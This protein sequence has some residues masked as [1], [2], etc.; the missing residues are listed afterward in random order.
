M[1]ELAYGAVPGNCESVLPTDEYTWLRSMGKALISQD[2]YETLRAA[3]QHVNLR[4]QPD[5]GWMDRRGALPC[6][7][8]QVYEKAIGCMDGRRG[9]FSNG[10]SSWGE[11]GWQNFGYESFTY[12]EPGEG[13]N[14]YPIGKWKGNGAPT[15]RG[16]ANSAL[17]VSEDGL[18]IFKLGTLSDP[19]KYAGDIDFGN[20]SAQNFSPAGTFVIGAQQ[21]VETVNSFIGGAVWL[22]DPAILRHFPKGSTI[23][24]ALLEMRQVG[25]VSF[26]SSTW[27]ERTQVPDLGGAL[28]AEAGYGTWANDIWYPDGSLAYPI[29]T[30]S[31]VTPQVGFGIIGQRASGTWDALGSFVEANS[32]TLA[33]NQTRVINVTS[34]VQ[35][36][37]DLRNS[38]YKQIALHLATVN[39][40]A[41]TVPAENGEYN[42]G[43]L[44][45]LVTGWSSFGASENGFEIDG[46]TPKYEFYGHTKALLSS[47]SIRFGTLFVQA[48]APTGVLN[49]YKVVY[50]NRPAMG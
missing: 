23:V 27:D 25:E 2:G 5:I 43:L 1:S 48:L 24:R 17:P 28:Q 33:Q 32:G 11:A 40:V 45:N 6:E 50:G 10:A 8:P 30:T 36:L 29:N 46:W 9:N 20:M 12:Y 42:F 39:G 47:A 15:V 7:V 41:S 44:E 37:C 21:H 31:P 13:G 4:M 26:D 22:V 35:A 34:T 19:A 18:D 49:T 38:P 3:G 14:P 16:I